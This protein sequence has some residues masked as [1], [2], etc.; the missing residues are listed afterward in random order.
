M[1]GHATIADLRMAE[2]ECAA[3]KLG[4][5]G[6]LYLGYRDSGM[7]GVPDNQ[8]HDALAKAPV[9]Q[10]AGRIVKLIRELKP[11]VVITHD[12]GGGYGHPDH[13][14]VH[15]ATL[16]AFYASSDPTQYPEAGK[17]YHPSKLY[18]AVR[19]HG[20]M[21]LVVRL[22]PL[23]GQDPHHFGRNKD[24]DCTKMIKE[25]YPVTAV[26]CLSKQALRIRNEV[27]A[28][29]ASQGGGRPRATP[30]RML[31]LYEKLRGPRDYYMRDYPPPRGRRERDLFE[32]L[33]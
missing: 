30:F 17:V 3:G 28:C 15:N 11:E 12:A 23:F 19:P 14:A 24:I 33:S 7:P 22:M 21:K 6:V 18:F 1:Q 32:G 29:H 8:H 31:G 26:V 5:A 10:V 4:L 20:L 16:K 9:E 13:I 2:M 27:S 25:E